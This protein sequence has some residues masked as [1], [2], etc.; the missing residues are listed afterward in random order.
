MQKNNTFHRLLLMLFLSV[1]VALA[2]SANVEYLTFTTVSGSPVVVALAE[3]PVITY[4]GNTVHIQTG[5]TT[6]DVSVASI[7]NIFFS[8]AVSTGIA[9]KLAAM[10]QMREG[11]V[12]FEQLPPGSAVT[13]H[14]LNGAQVSETNA[15]AQG[16]ADVNI[17]QLPAGVYIIKSVSQTI[18]ITVK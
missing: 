15:D 8:K 16:Q 10:P 13:V 12:F 2:R 14:A 18:K 3:H 7:T 6:I 9:E 11:A 17:A 5:S 4:T 1:N